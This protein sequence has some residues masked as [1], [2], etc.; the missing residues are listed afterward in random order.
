MAKRELLSPSHDTASRA[1]VDVQTATTHVKA[2]ITECV[3]KGISDEELTRRLNK[4]IAE[5]C[6]HI[7]DVGFREQLRKALVTSARKWHYELSQT[8]RI[9][10]ENFRRAAVKQ[11][12]NI[13]LSNLID[14]TPYQKQF[15]FRK[16]LDDGTNPGIPVIKDYQSS[17]KLAMKALSAEPPKIVTTKNGRTYVMPA[18]LRAEMAVRYA[19]AVE[20]LQ[21]LINEG[22]LFCWISS[23]PNCSP[24][25]SSY[26]GKLYSLFQGKVMIDGKEY[27]ERGVID[28]ISYRP[29]NEALAGP[30]GDGNGCISGYN[31]RHRA[32]EYERGSRPPEDFSKAQ[33]QREYAIDK[34]QRSYENR[35]RQLKQEERQLRACGMDKEA[36]A[37]RKKWRRLTK[38]YQIYSVEN[39]RAYYP[40]RYVID[41]TETNGLTE[42]ASDV[43]ITNENIKRPLGEKVVALQEA[44][45]NADPLVA[46]A[47]AR[48]QNKLSIKDAHFKTTEKDSAHFTPGEGIYFD[49]EEDSMPSNH[50]RKQYQTYFHETGHNLDYAIGKKISWLGGYA[51]NVY[52][53][54]NH[55]E[56]KLH[57]D[58]SG[59]V[60]G[61][62]LTNLSF[63]DM[64]KKEGKAFIDVY[65]QL[66][67]NRTG[68][69]AS[70]REVYEEI[71]RDFEEEPLVNKRQLSDILDGIT[72]GEML[73]MGFDLGA[74]HT[75]KKPN[76]WKTNSV[77]AEA[78][79]HFTGI[80]STNK[81]MIES[82]RAYF[83]KS[84]EIFEEI[85]NL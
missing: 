3:S 26:Q 66:V 80:L 68:K 35:I 69:K 19:A 75:R 30:N 21:R 55:I 60:I 70:K 33:M 83:P 76:Y 4:A 39:N 9:T 84:F 77:G 56:E 57:Y 51:S 34:Q 62:T 15:E 78:F 65:R 82:Y 43:I 2:L 16:L 23:H 49:I 58:K 11:P 50:S 28:G 85:L 48:Y 61:R 52:K 6:K 20:N 59:N 45:N 79:A 7:K 40:Y 71:F 54:P 13:E 42:Y 22:V 73:R 81:Q 74:S 37:V 27:G 47:I 24:R 1:I 72:N 38:D 46:N 14:K 5:E 18:R 12:F 36:S 10:E 8:Y 41:R 44:I 32:I 53:S 31:C 29:I 64:I 17:V 63:D 67:E 25:C